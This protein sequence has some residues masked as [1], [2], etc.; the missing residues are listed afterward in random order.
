MTVSS[1]GIAGNAHRQDAWQRCSQ[2]LAALPKPHFTL[3][4][5]A[6]LLLTRVGLF[7]LV[8][9]VLKIPP[10][11]DVADYYYPEACNALHG[12]LPNQDYHSSYSHC[13]SFIAALPV[14]CWHSP[15]SLILFAILLELGALP[16]WISIGEAIFGRVASYQATLL[17]VFNP[18]CL[19]NTAVFGTNQVWLAFFLALALYAQVRKNT[20]L[21]GLALGAGLMAVKIL[22]ALFIPAL[23]M[24]AP[25]KLRWA[26]GFL[27]PV[28]LVIGAGLLLGMDVLLP[29]KTES[30][31]HTSGN[32]PFLLSLA[33]VHP[34]AGWLHWLSYLVL[35]IVL[36]LLFA[37]V[38]RQRLHTDL[39]AVMYSLALTM[40]LFMLISSKS[41]TGYLVIALF[42]ICLCLCALWRSRWL[43]FVFILWSTVALC[44]TSLWY[45]L[46]GR[47]DLHLPAPPNTGLFLLIEMVLI[48][49]YL[50]YIRFIWQKGVCTLAASSSP[51]LP[52]GCS[53][54]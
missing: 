4:M 14:L 42:P 32:L 3:L 53:V 29:L 44:E 54:E 8:F 48:A 41:F 36:I 33:G 10:Q 7:F 37:Q 9:Q 6:A 22:G 49:G 47:G 2:W 18:L 25:K 20:F 51:Q 5:L 21:S 34:T 46:I 50:G 28:C 40:F 45:R 24:A 38:Y 43:P 13:F 52:R 35:T 1:P 12:L 31:R 19:V 16:L 23:A 17:Y 11:G 27:L 26:A 30:H 39:R 15:K